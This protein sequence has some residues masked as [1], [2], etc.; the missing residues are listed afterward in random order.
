MLALEPDERVWPIHVLVVED[1]P[2]L[3]SLLADEMREAGFTVVEAASADETLDYLH[4]N[5][6]ID[7]VFS[8][9]QMPG[10]LNGIGLAASL[11]ARDPMLPKGATRSSKRSYI[12]VPPDAMS[13]QQ[14]DRAGA[15]V[16]ASLG[17]G[18]QDKAE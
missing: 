15:E 7:L 6:D 3:R 5:R 8:D 12:C 18:E 2:L 4:G 1:E 16:V 14:V 17:L 9:I 13:I 10:S 11:H